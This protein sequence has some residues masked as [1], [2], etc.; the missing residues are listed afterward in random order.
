M[1][2]PRKTVTPEGRAEAWKRWW[3]KPILLG[4][5]ET[6]AAFDEFVEHFVPGH[7]QKQFFKFFG[8]PKSVFGN[9]FFYD[10]SVYHPLSMRF[11]SLLHDDQVIELTIIYGNEGDIEAHAM[12]GESRRSF[13]DAVIDDWHA[14]CGIARTPERTFYFFCEPKG[15]GCIVKTVLPD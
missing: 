11:A 13:K 8:K 4:D 14:A 7:M 9:R 12:R 1:A 5:E 6:S 3:S 15:R 10:D 2:R